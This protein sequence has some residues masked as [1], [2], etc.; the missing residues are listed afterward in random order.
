MTITSIESHLTHKYRG[1]SS[2]RAR[3]KQGQLIR[4][5]AQGEDAMQPDVEADLFI[6]GLVP[7]QLPHKSHAAR[8]RILFPG[9]SV[10]NDEISEIFC[11]APE[12]ACFQI[13][14][15]INRA[16]VQRRIPVLPRDFHYA[17]DDPDVIAAKMRLRGDFRDLLLRVKKQFPFD[18]MTTGNFGYF[19]EQEMAAAAEE[20]GIPFI[21]L[22]KECIA[23]DGLLPMLADIYRTRFDPFRG[24]RIL[25]YNETTRQLIGGSG[26]CAPRLIELGG[27]ARLDPLH[28]WR[29]RAAVKVRKTRLV[30]CF[31]PSRQS[32]LPGVLDSSDTRSWTELCRSLAHALVRFARADTSATVY[33]KTKPSHVDQ[34]AQLFAEFGAQPANLTIGAD[35][36]VTRL[37]QS[38]KAVVGFNT[39]TTLEAM[40]AGIPS[41]VPLFGEAS[42]PEYAPF[43]LDF[44]PGPIRV[45]SEAELLE[46][47]SALTKDAQSIPEEL[48]PDVRQS[49][50]NWV[51]NPDGGVG[52][53]L[54]RRLVEL[55]E[56][57]KSSNGRGGK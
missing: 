46:R 56:V 16:L 21:V 13:S 55:I 33:I 26:V 54:A 7:Y 47:L 22:H 32:Q 1:F 25:V 15:H 52:V 53:R 20:I 44:G 11:H 36:N 14:R 17:S 40:A 39:T 3:S 34:T 9:K 42:L 45:S 23:S 28:E 48:D 6:R 31:F 10:F 8:L 4:I 2:L 29:R 37:I 24:S 51:G 35:R 57:R 12:V 5:A 30:A 18:A 41:I 49:L 19:E 50:S 27:M 43:V 38:S